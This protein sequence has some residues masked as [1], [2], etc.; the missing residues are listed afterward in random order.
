MYESNGIFMWN[1]MLLLANIATVDGNN[2]DHGK[3]II[4]T[5]TGFTTGN[6]LDK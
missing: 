5:A 2:K 6:K 3:S 4:E 1:D